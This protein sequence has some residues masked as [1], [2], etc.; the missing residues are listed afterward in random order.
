MY[1]E[2]KKYPQQQR[3]ANYNTG[4]YK[5]KHVITSPQGVHV[6]VRNGEAVQNMFGNSLLQTVPD[7][8]RLKKTSFFRR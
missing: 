5:E 1:S 6:C 2:F 3:N 4:H 7:G 8:F